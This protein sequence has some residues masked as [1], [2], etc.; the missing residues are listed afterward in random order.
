VAGGTDGRR[1]P[2]AYTAKPFLISRNAAQKAEKK[3]V[4]IVALTRLS[5]R[6][7]AFNHGDE[8]IAYFVVRHMLTSGLLPEHAGERLPSMRERRARR[9][10]LRAVLQSLGTRQRLQLSHAA[11]SGEE[12]LEWVRQ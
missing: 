12:V 8:I 2:K 4:A 9:S 3:L 5:V 1:L 10:L 7:Y 11:A 6:H